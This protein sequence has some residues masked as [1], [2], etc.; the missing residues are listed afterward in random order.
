MKKTFN[1]GSKVIVSDPCYKI[2][3]WCQAVVKDVLPGTYVS[4]IDEYDGEDWGIRISKLRAIHQD[5]ILTRHHIKW[6]AHEVTIGVDS[7]QAGIFDF[8][9]YR[10]DDHSETYDLPL[11]FGDDWNSDK[12]DKWYQRMCA[13]TLSKEDNVLGLSEDGFGCSPDGVVSRSGYGDGPYTLF[14]GKVGDQIVGFEIEFIG[15]DDEDEDE[16]DDDED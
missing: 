7:G 6:T 3:T 14:I 13:L 12:G 15:E 16:E 1:L 11:I 9:H 2:P 8:D 10:D 4:E 5:H